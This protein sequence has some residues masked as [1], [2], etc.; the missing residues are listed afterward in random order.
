MKILL[1]Y[2]TGSHNHGC[3]AIVRTLAALLPEDDLILY[4]FDPD[5]DRQF[6]LD[7]LVTV[8]GCEPRKTAYSI[9]E[10]IR[11]RLHTY[12]QGQECYTR[13]LKEKPDWAFAI[14]GDNYCYPGQPEELAYLNREWK[15]R[16]VK[17]ALVGCSINEDVIARKTVQKDLNNYDLILARESLTA[18]ALKKQGI[19]NVKLLPDS[20]F[21]LP[22][23]TDN[24]IIER[25]DANTDTVGINLSPLVSRGEQK[26]GMV[27]RCYERLI[28]YLLDETPYHIL[29]IPH[30]FVPWDNDMDVLRRLYRAFADSGRI[31]LAEETD[32]RVLKGLVARCRYVVCARTHVSIAAYSQNIPTLVVGYSVKSEGIATD[33]FGTWEDDVL[34]AAK[35]T[36][37]DDLIKAFRRMMAGEEDIRNT[38]QQKNEL[39][40][41]QL[42][43]LPALIHGK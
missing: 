27:Y 18:E 32:C 17:T 39:Y 15:K 19:E 26:P 13:M 3:E 24:A 2:H 35:L 41:R 37:E 20:A 11:I 40:R 42:Q 36:G 23:K 28:Q 38:L 8:Q 34:E 29:L 4:S 14:G 12:Q 5:S 30:V 31:T 33:L 9:P 6:G 22:N 1:Y 10:R 7:D 21:V 25:I 16:K 43:E